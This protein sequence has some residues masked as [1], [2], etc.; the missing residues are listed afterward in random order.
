[1]DD[2]DDLA[3]RIAAYPVPAGQVVCWWLGGSGFVL[4]SSSGTQV[5][6]DP[7]LS[8]SVQAIFGQGRAF[9]TP[10]APDQAR[11]DVLIVTHWHEDHLDPGTIPLIA[12]HS[13]RCRFVM[14]PTAM[15]RALGWGVARDRVQ[16]LSA[17]ESLTIEG[18]GIAHVP[19]RHESG[20]PGWEVPDAMGVII[21]MAGVRIYHTGDTEY[22]GRLRGL[23]TEPPDVMMVCINGTGGNMNP[24][25]AALLAWHIEAGTVIP[26][27]HLLWANMG[28]A[29]T[30]DPALL[31]DTY[32]R[33]GG[34]GTV[35]A[36][37]VGT[38]L[39]LTHISTSHF[40]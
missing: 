20:I 7:Y 24:H 13:P 19:A 40:S 31:A 34:R 27:H 33:L 35:I 15:S 29:A 16:P 18:V 26:M 4:K 2:T 30:R 23:R 32:A 38:P 12:R 28:D 11:P 37:Q 17:G 36:P 14:P 21:T 10:I 22:D 3:T 5:Y 6:I 25:E 1:M 39:I 8:D 9:P